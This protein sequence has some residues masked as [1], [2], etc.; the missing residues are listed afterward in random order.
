MKIITGC[1][2]VLL[3]I[4]LS[5]LHLSNAYLR[6]STFDKVTVQ[7]GDDV[8]SI[9]EKYARN[10]TEIRKLTQAIHEVNALDHEGRL[11]PGQVLKVPLL[12]DSQN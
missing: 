12:A 10:N 8:W 6:A 1:F 9:A 3:L 11:V 4:A 5:P 2:L 7:Q